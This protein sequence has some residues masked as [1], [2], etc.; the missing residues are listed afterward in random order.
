MYTIFSLQVFVYLAQVVFVDIL[1]YLKIK[2]F[3]K[4]LTYKFHKYFLFPVEMVRGRTLTDPGKSSLIAIAKKKTRKQYFNIFK[5][6]IDD[7]SVVYQAV[8]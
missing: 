4:Q 2:T 3:F 7:Y 8:L 5:L 1:K 6:I